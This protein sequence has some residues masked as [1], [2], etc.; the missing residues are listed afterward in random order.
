MACTTILVGKD[1]SYDGSTLIA[2][3]HDAPGG[4]Y[5]AHKFVVIKPEEQPRKYKAVLSKVEIDLPDNPMRYTALPN[6]YLDDEGIWGGCGVNEAN[7]AMTA[8]ETITSNERVL[9]ADPLVVYKKAVGKVGDENYQPEQLGGVGEE[10]IVS[11]VLPYIKTAR[12]GVIRM[13]EILEKYGTCEMNGMAFQDEN[14]IWWLETIGGHHWIAKRVADDEYVTMPNQQ[15]ID[16]FDLEDA[17]G[18]K[19]NHLCSADMR[20]F[21]R[22]NH[23]DRTMDGEFNARDAFG[24]NSDA[25][26]TY[27]TPRS[28][29]IQRY[30]NPTENLWDGD[31]ADYRP[32]SDDIPWSRRPEKKITV[33]DI[34]YVLSNHFQGTKYDPYRGKGDLSS[35]GEFRSIGINRN[36]HLSIVQIR[37][38][39]PEA[40]K[41]IQWITLGSNVFNAIAPFY[42][43][44]DATPEYLA[45]TTLRVSTD[46][47]YWSNRLIAALAD[48]H[49]AANA[50]HIER[51]QNEVGASGRALLCE[52]D[53][54]FKAE[55]PKGKDVEKLLEEANSKVAEM[56]KKATDDTLNKVLFSSS[57]CMKNAFARSDA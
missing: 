41:A 28:W 15:G 32:D 48:A 25:D 49:F 54:K 33:E 23:L 47:F 20:E 42:T 21:I 44:I 38:Y 26:H 9:G 22:D 5:R 1:A 31:L 55:N 17:L 24:S 14:E 11:I 50:S 53:K 7:V 18:E 45:N 2:R 29:I 36:N 6:A 13:G 43:Q 30:F 35:R 34:K 46:N 51:Y 39:L 19:K 4:K 56:L 10:D 57:E 40:I 12:E 52:F 3:N 27:N 37:P 16:E 8:T